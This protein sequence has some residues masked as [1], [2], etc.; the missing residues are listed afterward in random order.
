MKRDWNP[1]Y[2]LLIISLISGVIVVLACIGLGTVL[3]WILN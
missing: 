2:G 1:F 3:S